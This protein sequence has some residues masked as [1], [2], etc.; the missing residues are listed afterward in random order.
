MLNLDKYNK[1]V[2]VNI[3]LELLQLTQPKDSSNFS[4]T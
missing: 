4:L 1:I 3:F 2:K